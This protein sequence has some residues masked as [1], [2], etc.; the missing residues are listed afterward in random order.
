[1][2]LFDSNANTT[3]S[4][5]SDK[6]NSSAGQDLI[7]IGQVSGKKNT[8]NI[9]LSRVE[10]AYNT[11]I[12]DSYNTDNRQ[13]FSGAYSGNSGNLTVTDGGAIDAMERAMSSFSQQTSNQLA[14]TQALAQ[15]VTT[16][17]QTVV[18]ETAAKIIKYISWGFGG[19]AVAFLATKVL[20]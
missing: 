12:S 19:L 10:D 9:D 2:G 6:S 11:D 16:G 14:T 18:A 3:T 7:D 1:V 13:D 4:D 20:K 8:Q 5:L 15:S 17:G